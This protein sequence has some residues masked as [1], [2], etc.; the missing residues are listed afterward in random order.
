MAMSCV[1]AAASTYSRAACAA[2][3]GT[4]RSAA[5][6]AAANDSVVSRRAAWCSGLA[7]TSATSLSSMPG[8]AAASVPWTIR[9]T[10]AHPGGVV[11]PASAMRRILA[12]PVRHFTRQI[13]ARFVGLLHSSDSMFE[14]SFSLFLAENLVLSAS[15]RSSGSCVKR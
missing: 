5:A 14:K 7:T 3:A 9:R 1:S 4:R 8:L 13:D 2:A 12:Q 6:A 15:W 10:L 11:M